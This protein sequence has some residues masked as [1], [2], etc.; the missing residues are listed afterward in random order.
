MSETTA[1]GGVH[2]PN[3]GAYA[4]PPGKPTLLRLGGSLGVAACV[5][6]LVILLAACHG[7]GASLKFSFI[8]LLLGGVGFVLSVVGAVI[9]KH[10][11]AHEDTHVLA[12]LFA[13]CMGIIGG[14]VQMAAWLKWPLLT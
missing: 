6:G 8:P 1:A 11:L 10:K 9:E 12:A 3:G 2:D 14:L 7:L 13:C 4:A 5:I